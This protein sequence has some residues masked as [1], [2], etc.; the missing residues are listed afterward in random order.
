MRADARQ[1]DNLKRWSDEDVRAAA[2]AA[3]GNARAR[4]DALRAAVV[5]AAARA[6]GVLT[7]LTTSVKTPEGIAD[8]LDRRRHLARRYSAAFVAER[9]EDLVRFTIVLDQEDYWQGARALIA[10]IQSVDLYIDEGEVKNFWLNSPRRYAGLNAY[11]LDA[12]GR[13]FE[14]QIHTPASR[15]WR[16][17]SHPAYE[18]HRQLKR[19]SP[20]ADAL[21]QSLTDD[22]M[23]AVAEPVGDS[24]LG[25][26]F[27]PRR[28]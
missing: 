28:G 19:G 8:K 20:E 6:G 22:C 14:I 24:D 4:A 21:N 9:L 16:Q 27:P 3:H 23:Q 26:P 11:P 17:E 1:G 15:Q 25:I 18:R 10:T 12:D 7:D 2:T 5:E 13:E